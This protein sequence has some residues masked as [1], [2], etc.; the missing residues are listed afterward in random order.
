M[1]LGDGKRPRRGAGGSPKTR[2]AGAHFQRLFCGFEGAEAT[3]RW[4]P[5]P[6]IESA[7]GS[8]CSA[9]AVVVSSNVIYN[10]GTLLGPG[11]GGDMNMHQQRAL[12]LLQQG[13]YE[14]AE[15]ELR[16][17]LGEDPQDPLAHSLLALCLSQRERFDE[18]THAAQ[19]AVHLAPDAGF[20]FYVLARVMV[21][22]NRDSEA[23]EAINEAIR[24]DPAD[25]R[26]YGCLALLHFRTRNWRQT[27]EAAR[28]GLA[29]DPDDDQCANLEAMALRKL[30]RTAD[31]DATIQRALER[32][33][34]DAYTHANRGWAL[35]EQGDHQQ[36]L[37]H[38]RES[39]RIDPS[40]DWAREG[41]TQALK[42][43]Y[44]IYRVFLGFFFWMA[45]LSRGAQWGIIIGGVVGIRVLRNLADANPDLKPFYWP[46]LGAYVG[47]VLMTWLAE[48][49][50]N[51]LLRLSRYGRLALS[52]EQVLTSNYVGGCLLAALGCIATAL[53]G[54]ALG[55]LDAAAALALS[56]LVFVLAVLPLSRVYD[57]EAGWPRISAILLCGAVLVIGLGGTGLML[58]GALLEPR[59]EAAVLS[60]LSYLLLGAL[61]LVAIGS[62]IGANLLVAARVRR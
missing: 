45:K 60:G 29:V 30:G 55:W 27:L 8:G 36:A 49:L 15:Q 53:V 9:A 11:H 59:V 20:P 52:R 31:A 1:A 58:A 57:C 40:L 3:A 51:L 46:L 17:S 35:L 26:Y 32:N 2:A 56:G 21:A 38:F 7:F 10:R 23:F 54:V 34:E 42:A 14:L 13:R 47:F 37:D 39:L 43:R 41:I 44:F 12:L 24:L 28:Q 61:P 16:K 5:I 6:N 33:P 50:F 4:A 22:R 48:P 25:E 18:A 19:H 62:Q